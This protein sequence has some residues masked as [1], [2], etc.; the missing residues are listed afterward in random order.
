MASRPTMVI[1]KAIKQKNI[2]AHCHGEMV[3][4]NMIIPLRSPTIGTPKLK[5]DIRLAL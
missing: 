2:P 3:S 5:G 4:L 1:T